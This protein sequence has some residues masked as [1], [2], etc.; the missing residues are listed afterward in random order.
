MTATGWKVFY[1]DKDTGKKGSGIIYTEVNDKPTKEQA[2]MELQAQLQLPLRYEVTSI[3]TYLYRRP[4]KYPATVGTEMDLEWELWD[5][6]K[7]DIK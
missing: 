1:I 6:M 5:W 4:Y 7:R 2:Q 3:R